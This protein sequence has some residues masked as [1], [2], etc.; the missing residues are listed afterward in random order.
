MKILAMADLH[1]D[2]KNDKYSY[3]GEC[4]TIVAGDI[5][6]DE[7]HGCCK[8]SNPEDRIPMSEWF[9]V[10]MTPFCCEKGRCDAR[11]LLVLGNHDR[12]VHENYSP[13][14][15]PQN[16][17][18]LCDQEMTVKTDKEVL[19]IYGTSWCPWDKEK[20]GSQKVR[21]QI[22]EDGPGMLRLQFGKIPEGLD[23]LISHCPPRCTKLIRRTSKELRDRLCEMSNPP[24]LVICGHSHGHGEQDVVEDELEGRNGKRIKIVCVAKNCKLIDFV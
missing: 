12:F 3:A 4:L 9:Q 23:I 7:K 11:V 2:L 8:A 20:R 16:A 5:A 18:L 13:E 6:C 22:F 10:Y 24:R 14:M 15:L 19:R 21:S 17:S 1:G